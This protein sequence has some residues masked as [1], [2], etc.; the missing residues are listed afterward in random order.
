ML[1]LNAL[2][3]YQLRDNNMLHTEHSAGVLPEIACFSCTV[4]FGR[5]LAQKFANI[6]LG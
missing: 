3:K 2:Q 1:D 5:Y 4:N 6:P